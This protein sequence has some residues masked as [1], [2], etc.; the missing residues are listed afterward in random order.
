MQPDA[1]KLPL[2]HRTPFSVDD[3]LDP[4]KFTKKKID[5]HAEIL[6]E[7]ST[8]R[9][10][11]KEKQQHP[12]DCCSPE[13]EEE[14]EEEAATPCSE[15]KVQRMRGKS[16]RIR[17]AFTLEQLQILER[18]FQRCHYLSVLERHT[19]SSALRLTETQVKIWFQNRRTKWKKERLQGKEAEEEQHGFPSSSL[20]PSS[21]SSSS[22]SSHPSSGSALTFSPLLCQQ[23]TPL[24]LYAPLPLVPYHYYR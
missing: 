14:E 7:A 1:A 3:I 24:H 12:G 18:S 8:P 13:E 22:Y 16:R 19:I 15:K 21:P 6:T 5:A 20:S 11:P 2:T 9:D 10:H 4:T 23:R 17:T